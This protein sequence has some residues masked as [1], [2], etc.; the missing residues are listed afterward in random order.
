MEKYI[1]DVE[2]ELEHKGDFY[3]RDKDGSYHRSNDLWSKIDPFK[4][5]ERSHYKD[6]TDDDLIS[7]LDDEYLKLI[8]PPE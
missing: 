7:R 2:V 6:V 3:V 8:T 5:N 4:Y 1:L